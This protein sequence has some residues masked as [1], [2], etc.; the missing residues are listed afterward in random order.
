MLPTNGLTFLG[1]SPPRPWP[2]SHPRRGGAQRVPP[3][4]G[5]GG[6]GQRVHQRD[7]GVVPR[8]AAGAARDGA[9]A[10]VS[11]PLLLLGGTEARPI[12]GRFYW[13]C[14]VDEGAHT[15]ARVR[16]RKHAHAHT[17]SHAVPC[18]RGAKFSAVIFGPLQSY[19]GRQTPT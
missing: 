13:P 4:R 11:G 3:Q 18:E 9:A 1:H 8:Q 6:Y 7:G 17:T 15:H 2:V 12:P 14:G 5:G 16:V 19:L 10:S